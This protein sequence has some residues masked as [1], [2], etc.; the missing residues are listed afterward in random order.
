LYS[1][2]TLF[3][4]LQGCTAQ[5]GPWNRSTIVAGVWNY[6]EEVIT[7]VMMRS[8]LF[9]MPDRSA[10]RIRLVMLAIVELLVTQYSEQVSL[11]SA[12]SL[13]TSSGDTLKLDLGELRKLG[14]S[15]EGM[16]SIIHAA[17]FSHCLVAVPGGILCKLLS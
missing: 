11:D 15:T 5:A 4:L 6:P 12:T 16:T 2:F 1:N 17:S 3:L 9:M 14:I 8:S 7:I 10:D 13:Y